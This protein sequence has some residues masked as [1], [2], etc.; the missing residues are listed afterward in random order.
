LTINFKSSRFHDAQ[1]GVRVCVLD[2]NII[3]RSSTRE[4]RSSVGQP[5][6]RQLSEDLKVERSYLFF[7]LT[8]YAN[9][10]HGNIQ[11]IREVFVFNIA[12]RRHRHPLK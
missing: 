6:Y 3:A 8:D 1:D 11:K 2:E 9:F 10:E 4:T 7:V 12:F 5:I